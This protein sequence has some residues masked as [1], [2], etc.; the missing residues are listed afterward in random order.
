MIFAYRIGDKDYLDTAWV[1]GGKFTATDHTGQRAKRLA[2]LTRGGPG[3]AEV[4]I[5]RGTLGRSA[6]RDRH[7]RAAVREYVESA[8]VLRRS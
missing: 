5:T 8:P 6:L 2:E 1:E 7:D 4:L 3:V